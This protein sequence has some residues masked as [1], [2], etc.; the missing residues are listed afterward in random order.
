MHSPAERHRDFMPGGSHTAHKDC[1][2]MLD[3]IAIV[4]GL[5]GFL[6][7]ILYG[8]LCERI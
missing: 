1:G 5:G 8:W 2:P 6:V 7:A 4:A 3:L